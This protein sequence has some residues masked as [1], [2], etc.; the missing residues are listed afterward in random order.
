MRW[1][2]F[3]GSRPARKPARNKM[4]G[5]GL[6][7]FFFLFVAF[8]GTKKKAQ[9]FTPLHLH[10]SRL[11]AQPQRLWG[12]KTTFCPAPHNRGGWDG[13]WSWDLSPGSSQW[14]QPEHNQHEVNCCAPAQ[15]C[16]CIS[17]GFR[18]NTSGLVLVKILFQEK[19]HYC[20][21]RREGRT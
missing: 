9:P 12:T 18:L 5:F 21:P 6:L 15:P 14:L 10:L 13:H 11:E 2:P 7:Y 1:R 19:H 17:A 3:P 16:T 4:V 20:F 8:L